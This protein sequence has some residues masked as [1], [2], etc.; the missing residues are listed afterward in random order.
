MS[1]DLEGAA[2]SAASVPHHGE[3]TKEASD[4]GL[5][6]LLTFFLLALISAA[7]WYFM[8]AGGNKHGEVAA[9][10][11]SDST[12]NAEMHTATSAVTG[13]VDSSGNF[14]YETGKMVT[15]VLPND[16]GTLTVG[17]NS[18]ENKLYKFLADPNAAID[19]VKG[20]WFEFTNVRFATG[21]SKV[22]SASYAQLLNI[23]AISK[24]FPAASFKLGGYTDNTGDSVANVVLSQ[25]RAEAVAAALVKSG[26]SSTAITGAKGYGPQH[27]IG[28]NSTEA[29]KAMNRRVAINVKSK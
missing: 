6:W 21:G 15:I 9:T 29:G 7:V 17:E 16:A 8:G 19:T 12:V 22:D 28:D 23:V 14:I 1:N 11:G 4:S 2:K 13:T 10:H 26:A 24:G 25:N 20:N 5:P 3:A 27:P 18:T